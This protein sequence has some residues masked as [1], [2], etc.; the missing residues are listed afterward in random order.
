MNTPADQ[1]ALA[2]SYA[3]TALVKALYKSGALTQDD[4]FQ[5]LAG[6]TQS[7]QRVGEVDAA[8][9]LGDLAQSFQGVED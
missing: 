8:R 2:M 1:K 9:L 3:F 6:A 4:L 5:E 7:L